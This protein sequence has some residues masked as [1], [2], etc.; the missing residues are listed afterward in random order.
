MAL[1]GLATTLI[2]FLLEDDSR[3][4]FKWLIVLKPYFGYI[5]FSKIM[6]D[7]AEIALHHS[8]GDAE[9][10]AARRSVRF[11]PHLVEAA[12]NFRRNYLNSSDTSDL[13]T[14]S[15]D[16]RNDKQVSFTGALFVYRGMAKF[17]FAAH[18]EN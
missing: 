3:Y 18:I 4:A 9:Y 1:Q 5:N 7:R 10:W 13:T 15:S 11:A 8:F 16:W 17:K 2:S 14:L 12:S 6:L